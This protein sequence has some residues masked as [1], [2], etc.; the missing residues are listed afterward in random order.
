MFTVRSQYSTEQFQW[1]FSL[2]NLCLFDYSTVHL[3]TWKAKLESSHFN[4]ISSFPNLRC[5]SPPE[6]EGFSV[7]REVGDRCK[8]EGIGDIRKPSTQVE[9]KEENG[10]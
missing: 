7:K 10:A 8:Q 9:E 6:T 5:N 4:F 1:R 2:R 3:K